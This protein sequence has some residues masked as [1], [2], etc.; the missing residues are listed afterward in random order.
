MGFLKKAFK[1][2]KGVVGDVVDG[3]VGGIEKITGIDL[4]KVLNNK[5]VKGG[6]MAASLVTGGIAIVNGVM[7]G[8]NA[9]SG[10]TGFMSKFV[11]GASAF[12]KGAGSGLANPIDTA[13]GWMGGAADA[14]GTVAGGLTGADIAPESLAGETSGAA[15]AA[16]GIDKGQIAADIGERAGEQIGAKAIQPLSAQTPAGVPGQMNMPDVAASRDMLDP[17]SWSGGDMNLATGGEFAPMTP[18]VDA[19]TAG[20]PD[21]MGAQLA[22]QAEPGFMSKL[23]RGVSDFVTS[24]K[25]ITTLA[26]AAQGWAQGAAIEE[27]W[28]QM[29]RE[30]NKRRRSFEGFSSRAPTVNIPA[31]SDL[32]QRGRSVQNRGN[33]TQARYGYGS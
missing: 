29:Q 10:A 6:L 9:A 31:L 8:F 11:E 2:V 18:G 27:R 25:G 19:A 5:W 24:P 4:K 13:K 33:Q 17:A 23:G 15:Q 26:N 21:A 30:E 12:V 14:A 20:I 3:V 32:R 28:D 7:Q 22:Q 1:K 16:A